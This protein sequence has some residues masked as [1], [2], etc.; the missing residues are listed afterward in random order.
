MKAFAFDMCVNAL[1]TLSDCKPNHRSTSTDRTAK[2]STVERKK[3][4]GG[5]EGWKKGR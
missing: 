3:K 1:Q 5:K 4:E 2:Y